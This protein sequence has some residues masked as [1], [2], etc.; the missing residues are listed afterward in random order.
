MTRVLILG[1]AAVQADAVTSAPADYGAVSKLGPPLPA[2]LGQPIA[3][4]QQEGEAVPMPTPGT[5]PSA[6]DPAAEA[7]ERAAQE[8]EAEA[9]EAARILQVGWREA[10]DIPDGQVENTWEN[11]IKV[12]SVIRRL[13][14]RVVILPYWK[15]RHP[16]HATAAK[17][18]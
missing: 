4:A 16:D 11:R 6:R 1:A 7:R 3:A 9:T 8:R 17:L 14:P 13:R 5:P 15:A 18:G 10:L 12:A 2:D